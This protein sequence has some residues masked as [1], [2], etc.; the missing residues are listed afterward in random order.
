MDESTHRYYA[1]FDD[2]QA[3]AYESAEGGVANYF[4]LAFPPGARVLDL[5]CGTARDTALLACESREVYGVEPV[6]R[7]RELAISHHPELVDRILAGELPEQLPGCELTGG[8]FDGIVC[9]AVLQHLPRHQLFDAVFSIRERLVERGRLLLSIPKVSTDSPD[10][11]RDE[12]GRLCNGV[13]I[14]ELDLLFERGGFQSIGRWE[15]P[16][17]LGRSERVWVVSLYERRTAA[18]SRPLD[19]IEAILRRDRKVATYKLALIRALADIA[20]T[21]PHTVTWLADDDVGVPVATIAEL[22]VRYYWPFFERAGELFVPQTAG[23]WSRQESGARF[24]KELQEVVDHYRHAGG[25]AQYL[26]DRKDR[27][28]SAD[29]EGLDAALMR[30]LRI[31]IQKGPVTHAGV[32]TSPD[33]RSA[34]GNHGGTV[35]IPGDLWRELSLMGHWIRDSLILRWSEL[36]S[37]LSRGNVRPEE[38]VSI[39]LSAPN[40]ERETRTARAVYESHP[41]LFCVWTDAPV[42]PQSMEVDHVIPYAVWRNNDLWNLLPA[43]KK[44]N[45][46]KRDR[47]PTHALLRSRR[48]AIEHYWDLTRTGHRRR[49]EH[50]AAIL[51]GTPKPSLNRIYHALTESVEITA[52][53]RGC[54]RWEP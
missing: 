35:L 25:L 38:I 20:V 27:S 4:P 54:E 45:Q 7:M 39:L 14:G 53:Q 44:V 49:F 12:H 37:S 40:S 36:S 42:R 30:K 50:E 21:R 46:S 24:R 22:W 32:S 15:N 1:R 6:R 17:S 18:S 48:E 29:V 43:S 31:T 10:I 28:W 2:A 34:F 33:G 23:D 9:S 16:D 52:M 13:S 3:A 8:P 11:D 5:G 19:R 41:G 26:A 47:L 51:V